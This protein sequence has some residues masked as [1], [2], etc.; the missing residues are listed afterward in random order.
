[1]SIKLK[2][3]KVRKS[4][5]RLLITYTG[6]LLTLMRPIYLLTLCQWL[7]ATLVK[8]RGNKD[9]THLHPEKRQYNVDLLV[10]KIGPN[11]T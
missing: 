10:L 4:P 3:K 8:V 5:W 6:D 9:G 11:I 7:S 2:F 1:M